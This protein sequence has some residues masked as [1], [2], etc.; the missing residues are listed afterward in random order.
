MEQPSLESS[1]SKL[2]MG[3]NIEFCLVCGD[4]ASGRHYGKKFSKKINI[5][6]NFSDFC[7]KVLSAVKDVKAFL[8]DRFANNSAISAEEP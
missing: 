8:K 7:F 5:L 4:R 2:D 1:Q 6:S 3:S